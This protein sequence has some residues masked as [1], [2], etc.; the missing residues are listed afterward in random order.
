MSLWFILILAVLW[1]LFWCSPDI[2][3]YMDDLA[4]RLEQRI[5]ELKRERERERE[6]DRDP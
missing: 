1:V 3:R 2:A 4:R 5:W 6:I